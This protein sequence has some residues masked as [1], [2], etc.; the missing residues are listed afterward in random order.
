MTVTETLAALERGELTTEQ[1]AAEF[2]DR[3]WS[4]PAGKTTLAEIETDPDPTPSP[5][6]SFADVEL[7][8]V[9]GKIDANQYEIFVQAASPY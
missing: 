6:D 2:A 4:A 5:P 1:V 8:Y 7:A 3:S 9:I